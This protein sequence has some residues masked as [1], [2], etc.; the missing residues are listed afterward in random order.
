VP[1]SPYFTVGAVP[2][3]TGEHI[4]SRPLCDLCR[5][6]S[7]LCLPDPRPSA[8]KTQQAHYVAASAPLPPP[9]PSDRGSLERARHMYARLILHATTA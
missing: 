6:V 3:F 1:T 7:C 8:V 4:S 9:R 2:A 5:T